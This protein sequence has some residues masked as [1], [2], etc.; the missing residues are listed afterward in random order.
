MV[1]FPTT[2]LNGTSTDT[3]KARETAGSRRPS[4]LG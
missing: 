3:D 2:H 4:C 1:K